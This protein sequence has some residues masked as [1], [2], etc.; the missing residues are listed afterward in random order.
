MVQR[1]VVR[2]LFDPGFRERVYAAPEAA[3]HDVPLTAEERQW[4]ITPPPQAYG[5]M[6][7]G[8]VGR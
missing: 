3:L 8:R 6:S 4:V 2:M 7:T 5:W 1:V